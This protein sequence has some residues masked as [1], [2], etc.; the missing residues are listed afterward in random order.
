[1]STAF[2]NG[3]LRLNT[4]SELRAW[5]QTGEIAASATVVYVV[6][7]IIWRAA[8]DPGGVENV[9]QSGGPGKSGFRAGSLAA[10]GG[11]GRPGHGVYCGLGGAIYALRAFFREARQFCPRCFPPK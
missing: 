1:M 10:E 4:V 11:S 5:M 3:V 7:T 8:L 2:Q 9:V 6:N